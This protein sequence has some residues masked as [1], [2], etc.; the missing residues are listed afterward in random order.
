MRPKHALWLAAAVIWSAWFVMDPEARVD[1]PGASE[2]NSAG[3][4]IDVE[5]SQR[6]ILSQHF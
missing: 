4:V 5:T 6:T 1:T 3:D 2:R